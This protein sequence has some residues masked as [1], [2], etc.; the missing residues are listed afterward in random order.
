MVFIREKINRSG[1]IS[2]QIVSKENGAS[3][4]LKTVG[5]ATERP[6]LESLKIQAQQLMG[7]IKHQPSLLHSERDELL[8]QSIASLNN[9][10]I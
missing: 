2:I 4:V 8:M 9:N 7:E 1:T 3:K 10:N 5:Y 6:E